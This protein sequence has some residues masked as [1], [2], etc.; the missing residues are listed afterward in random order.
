MASDVQETSTN[1]TR[2]VVLGSEDHTLTGSDR[3]S[4]CFSF[5]SDRPGILVDVLGEFAKRNINLAKIESRPSKGSLGQYIFLVDLDGHRS[6]K[7]VK[8]ALARISK[9]T[10]RL[11][12]FGSYPRFSIF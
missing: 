1:V 6:D 5:D 4:L 11:S 9:V 3:T 10:S 7:L 12:I 2:F 8:E